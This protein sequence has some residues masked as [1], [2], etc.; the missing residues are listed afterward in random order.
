M[1]T[2]ALVKRVAGWAVLGCCGLDWFYK[3]V[4]Y[5]ARVEGGSMFPVLNPDKLQLDKPDYVVLKRLNGNY[6]DIHRGDI[7][8]S[9][10]PNNAHDIYI[11][12][13]VG[14]P[15]D[16]VKTLR[17][18]R[19]ALRIPE[20]HCWI[21]GDNHSLSIDSNDFGPVPLGLIQSKAIGVILPLHRRR[22]LVHDVTN[23]HQTR[24]KQF[25]P[26]EDGPEKIDVADALI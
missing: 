18:R 2:A 25:S 20:G 15:G 6:D 16:F 4:G 11:K 10:C 12:R 26:E 19:K 3:Q 23:D 21:E 1:A 17:Y 5:V 13:I 7:V 22:L 9:V 14:L 24:V 8:T